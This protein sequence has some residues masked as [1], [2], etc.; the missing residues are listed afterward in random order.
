M[1]LAIW[2]STRVARSASSCAVS[3]AFGAQ[4]ATLTSYTTTAMP[5]SVAW[6]MSRHIGGEQ[7]TRGGRAPRAHNNAGDGRRY[8]GFHVGGLSGIVGLRIVELHG[9]AD[10]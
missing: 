8:R 9:E 7:R 3:T 10:R 4:S 6:L 5:A 1:S 2:V